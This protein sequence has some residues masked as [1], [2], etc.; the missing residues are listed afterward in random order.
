[1]AQFALRTAKGLDRWILLV[2]LAFT[3]TLLHRSEDMTL[4][5][6]AR[7]TLYAHVP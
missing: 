5:E 4:Q 7:L 1:M 3:L 6:A 2:F